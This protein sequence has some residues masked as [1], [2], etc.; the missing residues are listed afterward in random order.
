MIVGKFVAKG[1]QS[2][3]CSW[4]GGC[5]F[6]SSRSSSSFV[7]CGELKKMKSVNNPG[8][9]CQLAKT[10]TSILYYSS[11]L[12]HCRKCLYVPLKG[13]CLISCLKQAL[14]V[15]PFGGTS[16]AYFL[17]MCVYVYPFAPSIKDMS[18]TCTDCTV[19]CT[20][21]R[22]RQYRNQSWGHFVG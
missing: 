22:T 1:V 6:V 16:E 20:A 8:D 11:T 17:G 10:R 19:P 14:T 12:R 9:E 5:G 2:S 3:S 4:F 7:L 18:D 21:P 15:S 13:Y